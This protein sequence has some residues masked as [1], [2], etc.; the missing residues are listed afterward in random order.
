MKP[1]SNILVLRYR[2]EIP[3]HNSLTHPLADDVVLPSNC[4]S[5]RCS[6][7]RL[8]SQSTANRCANIMQ[9]LIP[10]SQRTL[11]EARKCSLAILT[12]LFLALVGGPRYA[13]HPSNTEEASGIDLTELSLEELLNIEVTIA[14]RSAQ[15]LSDIPGAVY[16][17][18]GDEIRRAGHTS[19][20]EALRMVPGLRRTGPSSLSVNP[21]DSSTKARTA[22]FIQ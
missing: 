9:R 12:V 3:P 11:L 1:Q 17:V 16:V 22:T 15:K 7:R 2:S 10:Q 4:A 6:C 13:N 8:G 21:K 5:S 20:Q 19:V 14:T 18:S